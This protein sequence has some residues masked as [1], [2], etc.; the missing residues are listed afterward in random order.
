MR[1]AER[2]TESVHP[3][4][5][6]AHLLQGLGFAAAAAIA[7]AAEVSAAAAAAPLAAMGFAETLVAVASVVG[8]AAAAQTATEPD[9]LCRAD[10]AGSPSH[11]VDTSQAGRLPHQRRWGAFAR[12]SIV[13]LTVMGSGS[14]W[15]PKQ[16]RVVPFKARWKASPGETLG[17][18]QEKDSCTIRR[19]QGAA[20]N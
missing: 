1:F 4:T 12:T 6:V 16:R 13:P 20:E 15:P 18:R 14:G 9:S 7:A 17:V 10:F 8:A 19:V 2:P 11:T 3:E 5:A